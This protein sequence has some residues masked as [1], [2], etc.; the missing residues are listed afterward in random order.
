MAAVEIVLST[1]LVAVPA[2]IRVEPVSAS[3]PTFGR[4]STSH[5]STRTFGGSEQ[6]RRPV[7]APIVWARDSAART[8][9]VVPLAAMPSTKSGGDTRA[10]SIASIPAFTSSSA[11][12]RPFTRDW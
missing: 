3:G 1:S 6:E 10:R 9:G 8:N 7:A 12:S 2:F 5:V 11:P 4:I